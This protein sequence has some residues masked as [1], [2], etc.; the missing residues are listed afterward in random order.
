MPLLSQLKAH[1]YK[2]LFWFCAFLKEKI[3]FYRK[4]SLFSSLTSWGCDFLYFKPYCQVKY[5]IWISFSVCW[6][7]GNYYLNYHCHYRSNGNF[8]R[9]HPIA[10]RVRTYLVTLF[11]SQRFYSYGNYQLYWKGNGV[12]GRVGLGVRC[13]KNWVVRKLF[14]TY[15]LFEIHISSGAWKCV[16][17]IS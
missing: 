1:M 12:W 3:L 4:F 15:D 13:C 16:G 9:G 8:T 17:G 6:Q 11:E 7:H 5:L 2:L 14:Q 10:L